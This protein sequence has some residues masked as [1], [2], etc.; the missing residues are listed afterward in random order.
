MY[1]SEYSSYSIPNYSTG[2]TVLSDCPSL[3]QEPIE[4]KCYCCYIWLG[5]KISP[6]Y[7]D[8][9]VSTPYTASILEGLRRN[10]LSQ[11]ESSVLSLSVSTHMRVSSSNG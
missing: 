3:P 7:L 2:T 6:T 9:S 8:H 10:K 5:W 4:V 1:W 11:S